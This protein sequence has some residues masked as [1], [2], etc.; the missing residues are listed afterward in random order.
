VEATVIY[1]LLVHKGDRGDHPPPRHHWTWTD[2]VVTLTVVTVLT[3]IVV[4]S[5]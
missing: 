5:L 3:L 1:G 4:G 2:V